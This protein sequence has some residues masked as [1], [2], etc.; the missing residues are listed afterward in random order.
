MEKLG[1]STIHLV[2][3]SEQ[4]SQNELENLQKIKREYPG[5]NVHL[6]LVHG[7]ETDVTASRYVNPLKSLFYFVYNVS[8]FNLLM[9]L[10][11]H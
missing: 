10:S 9:K 3:S 2:H 4:W 7:D 5:Y 1:N 11:L 8:E 6:V